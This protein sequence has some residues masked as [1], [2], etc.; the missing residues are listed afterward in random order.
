MAV[1]RRAGIL[2]MSYFC[3]KPTF[4]RST[5]V[6][7]TKPSI[8]SSNTSSYLWVKRTKI[9]QTPALTLSSGPDSSSSAVSS[10]GLLYVRYLCSMAMIDLILVS[11]SGGRSWQLRSKKILKSR[12]NVWERPINACL[13][14]LLFSIS[15][16]V[17]YTHMSA[18]N[19]LSLVSLH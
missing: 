7:L 1:Y 3:S 16:S 13:L 15:W 19:P 17:D 9:S 18:C 11:K 5:H 12:F 14:S 2:T 6:E 4:V 8:N 10:S